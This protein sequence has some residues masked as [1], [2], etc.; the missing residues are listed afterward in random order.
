MDWTGLDS[1][2][3]SGVVLA[4]IRRA[5]S[6]GELL[7]DKLCGACDSH[8]DSPD[9]ELHTGLFANSGTIQRTPVRI[10]DYSEK[11]L[12]KWNNPVLA[13]IFRT[14]EGRRTTQFF[15][16]SALV[17]SHAGMGPCRVPLLALAPLRMKAPQLAMAPQSLPV[18]VQQYQVVDLLYGS[19]E[20]AL[21]A[22]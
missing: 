12:K 1:G 7:S 17:C 5:L 15:N 20:R 21:G 9:C 11:I 3:D 2:L 16:S 14:T 8:L 22:A 4:L 19:I 18:R 10:V 13:R 6:W